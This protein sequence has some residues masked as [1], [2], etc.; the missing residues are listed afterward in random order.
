MF[1]VSVKYCKVMLITRG[2]G[3]GAHPYKRDCRLQI[4]VSFK[5]FGMKSHDI[6]P[7]RYRLGLCVKIMYKKCY[8]T[9]L[10]E[11]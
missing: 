10:T 6:C 4:F 9:D 8:D 1:L 3:G 7:F 11:I 5:V 2:A